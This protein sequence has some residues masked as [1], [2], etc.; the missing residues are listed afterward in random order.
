[1]NQN[2]KEKS[3]KCNCERGLCCFGK[4]ST[5]KCKCPPLQQEKECKFCTGR[6]VGDLENTTGDDKLWREHQYHPQKT[7][8]L[9]EPIKEEV[10]SAYKGASYPSMSDYF[11]KIPKPSADKGEGK[12]PSDRISEIYEEILAKDENKYFELIVLQSIIDYLDEQ[13]KL[14]TKI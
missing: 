14:S 9:A 13:S 4:P 1:M 12:L 10:M 11:K 7:N 8:T 5:E 2:N 6:K 3:N